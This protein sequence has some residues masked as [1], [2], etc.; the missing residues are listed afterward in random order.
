[1]LKKTITAAL[2]VVLGATLAF[3]GPG[4]GHHGRGKGAILRFSEELNLSEAQK[5]QIKDMQQSFR[6]QNQTLMDQFKQTARD[7]REAKRSGD[8]AKA[9]SFKTVFESQKIQVQ[10]LHKSLESQIMNVLTAEQRAKYEALKAEHAQRRNEW[11]SNKGE[12]E[13]KKQQ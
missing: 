7:Y 4:E 8:K 2:A 9:D 13:E 6:E 1:M 11:K 3:A 12:K 5:T 10:N